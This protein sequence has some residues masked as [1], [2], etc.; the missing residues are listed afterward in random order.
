MNPGR[1][2]QLTVFVGAFF[3]IYYVNLKRPN[4][5]FKFKILVLVE[6]KLF[7][8]QAALQ[9]GHITDLEFTEKLQDSFIQAILKTVNYMGLERSNF[10]MIQQKVH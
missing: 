7:P 3:N 8:F 2:R 4:K 10:L 9:M 6:L 5:R 1:M